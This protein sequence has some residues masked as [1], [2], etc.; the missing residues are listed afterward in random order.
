MNTKYKQ[1]KEKSCADKP[2]AAVKHFN[3]AAASHLT[4]ITIVFPK[5]RKMTPAKYLIT[6]IEISR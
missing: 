1:D 2:N 6:H 4:T 5:P 3:N